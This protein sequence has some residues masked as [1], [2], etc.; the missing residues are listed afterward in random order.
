[1]PRVKSTPQNAHTPFEN[2]TTLTPG[3]VAAFTKLR[4]GLVIAR[5]FLRYPGGGGAIPEE[6]PSS[7]NWVLGMADAVPIRDET[8]GE[9]TSFAML[10]SVAR[11]PDGLH[12]PRS[13]MKGTKTPT[14]QSKATKLDFGS[15]NTGS[16]VK[17]PQRQASLT[18]AEKHELHE[19]SAEHA[20]HPKPVGS[21]HAAA[22]ALSDVPHSHGRA[23]RAAD[24][25]NAAVP[26]GISVI[27]ESPTATHYHSNLPGVRVLGTVDAVEKQKRDYEEMRREKQAAHLKAIRKKKKLSAA[28][29]RLLQ[30]ASAGYNIPLFRPLTVEERM[31]TFKRDAVAAFADMEKLKQANEEMTAEAR[32][33]VSGRRDSKIGELIVFECGGFA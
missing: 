14:S 4:W 30:A 28:S 3:E 23:A 15:A 7:I 20:K 27:G 11:K 17:S 5:E 26:P 33:I 21:D 22:S 29:S 31:N 13:C 10:P 12:K 16:A 32:D 25:S 19:I 9:V 18:S 24:D 1:M 2:G 8:S 6:E